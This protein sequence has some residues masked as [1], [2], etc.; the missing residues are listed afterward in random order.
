MAAFARKR[1]WA[2]ELHKI[3]SY[4]DKTTSRPIRK[5]WPVLEPQ[6]REASIE[7]IHIQI[8]SINSAQKRGQLWKDISYCNTKQR[9][10]IARPSRIDWVALCTRVNIWL[11]VGYSSRLLLCHSS[12][13]VKHQ[14]SKCAHGGWHDWLGSVFTWWRLKEMSDFDSEA[15]VGKPWTSRIESEHFGAFSS[16]CPVRNGEIDTEEA[17]WKMREDQT[18]ERE[19]THTHALRHSQVRETERA[20]QKVSYDHKK[21]NHPI[22]KRRPG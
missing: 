21:T 1:E 12:S 2:R 4:L 13:S 8:D 10:P 5:M 18:W 20:P 6:E 7:P 14:N 19:K 3:V 11:N 22:Q 15:R 16:N 9:V 17:A